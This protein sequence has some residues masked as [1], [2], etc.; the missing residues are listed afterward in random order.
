MAAGG[1]RRRGVAA[2]RAA[3]RIFLTVGSAA[4]E[5]K[6]LLAVA[7]GDRRSAAPQRP[8]AFF[9]SCGKERRHRGGGGRQGGE[10][11]GL[12]PGDEALPV[13]GVEPGRLRRSVGRGRRGLGCG[14]RCHVR[15]HHVWRRR[16]AGRAVEPLGCHLRC[17]AGCMLPASP[18]RLPTGELPAAPPVSRLPGRGAVAQPAATGAESRAIFAGC[19]NCGNPCNRRGKRSGEN[20]LP[21]T[22][23][24]APSRWNP[25]NRVRP[26]CVRDRE[27]PLSEA[28]LGPVSPQIRDERAPGPRYGR[29]RAWVSAPL[30]S[31]RAPAPADAPRVPATSANDRLQTPC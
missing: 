17:C 6:A 18:P 2:R 12:A 11:G 1:G 22:R 9:P 4:G 13:G 3:L 29:A 24:V 25:C 28:A 23:L 31:P 7:V 16:G 8:G 30:P 19:G 21:I 27:V 26:S 10:T 15:G 14:G 5:G 20:L